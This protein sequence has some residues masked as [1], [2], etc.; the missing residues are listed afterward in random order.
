MEDIREE[1][2]RIAELLYQEKKDDAYAGIS[3]MIPMLMEYTS[4]IQDDEK[5]TKLISVLGSA[6]EA[7]EQ[8]DLTLLAD[9]LQY[10][11]IEELA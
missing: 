1:I 2:E 11:L 5:K 6:L 10:D 7:M 8:E 4:E 9:I 3:Q